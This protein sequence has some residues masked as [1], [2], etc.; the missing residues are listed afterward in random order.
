MR[1]MFQYP[2]AHGSERD[3]LD[4][5]AVGTIAMALE[6]AGWHGLAFTEHPAPGSRW[7]H[8]GGHQSLDPFVALAGAAT[9]TKQLQLLTYLAVIPY[10]NPLLLAKSA[11][12]LDR[13]SDGRFI[14]GAGTGYLKGEFRALGVDFDERNALFDEALDALALHWS[15][16]P[17]SYEGR[18]W[19][20]RESQG[21][22]RPTR[23]TIPIWLGGNAKVTLQ[24]VAE[25]CQGWMPLFGSEQLFSTTR[26]PHPG[27]LADVAAK[28]EQLRTEASG[29]GA[30]IDLV[31]PY[32][33]PSIANPTEEAERHREAFAGLED[34]GATWCV[35]HGA[36]G[37][38][39]EVLAFI[40]SFAENYLR[41]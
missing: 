36:A 13:L 34:A 41:Q 35:I 33:D 5:G 16:E 10:R 21:L 19:K 39:A 2:D 12:T 37:T 23:G 20:A 29:R 15:G 9:V 27:T 30:E 6:E 18:H 17:F 26:T 11:T 7:L 32:M 3:M 28:I 40:E 8:A 25:R 1:F 14:L 22:P 24:R 38:E 4:S 31:L